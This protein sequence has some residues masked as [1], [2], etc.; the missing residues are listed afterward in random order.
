MAVAPGTDW[1]GAEEAITFL[2]EP[3]SHRAHRHGWQ[4]AV[5]ICDKESLAFHSPFIP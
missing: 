5:C 4:G 1:T 2:R 3:S